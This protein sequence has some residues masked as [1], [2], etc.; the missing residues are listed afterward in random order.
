MM[1]KNLNVDGM[2]D[3]IFFVPDS[4]RLRINTLLPF[5]PI[6]H[7]TPTFLHE[8]FFAILTDDDE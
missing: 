8:K 7:V 3:A 4:T 1:N 5:F 2:I 6:T